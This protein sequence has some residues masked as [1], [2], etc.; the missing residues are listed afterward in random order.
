MSARVQVQQPAGQREVALDRDVVRF[1][2]D[3]GCDVVLEE[4]GI[5]AE[6]FELRRADG[7][8]KVVD[9][10]SRNGTRLNGAFV[11][12]SA[13]KDGDVLH[14]GAV[15]VVFQADAGRPSGVAAPVAAA[16]IARGA[17]P[18]PSR[19]AAPAAA[20]R[21]RARDEEPQ[22]EA[23]ERRGRARRVRRGSNSTVIIA[24]IVLV[25]AAAVGILVLATS[26]TESPNRV[27]RRQMLDA[28][29]RGNWEKM[30]ELA[31][32]ADPND[33]DPVDYEAIQEMRAEAEIGR[34]GAADSAVA[35]V[36]DRAWN[37]IRVW[38]Q[39]TEWKD[40]PGYIAKL[41]EYIAQHGTM[42]TS[43][44]HSAKKERTKLTGTTRPGAPA[45]AAEALTL[46][47]ED[48]VYLNELG[49]YGESVRRI[50]AFLQEHAGAVA[51]AAGIA[52]DL[53]RATTEQVSKWFA[54]QVS[55]AWH[56][57]DNDDWGRAIQTME[58]ARDRVG[59]PEFQKRADDEIRKIQEHRAGNKR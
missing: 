33:P 34:K 10:E 41:D 14:A 40:D 35:T 58:T 11:N 51:G 6:H 36:A 49:M 1:G 5:S 54:T 25:V 20:Q 27:V 46:L 22:E 53:R 7:G 29:A 42:Q 2:R 31:A 39:K 23:T 16:P 21:R 4:P 59:I 47:R 44:V 8:W 38:R 43:G 55:V 24:L 48:V 18:A 17:A 15:R 12:Q 28:Q 19:K 45:T 3:R 26:K 32:Q 37:D 57:V 9:L 56:K 50:D 30:L 52:E 13:L